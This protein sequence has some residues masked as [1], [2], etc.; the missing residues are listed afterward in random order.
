[1]AGHQCLRR[2]LLVTG[3]LWGHLPD[4]AG[5]AKVASVSIVIETIGLVLIWAAPSAGLAITGTVM[6]GLGY[7]LGHRRARRLRHRRESERDQ[8]AAGEAFSWTD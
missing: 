1:M 5:E 2:R 4:V 8:H 7:A 6:T 3:V